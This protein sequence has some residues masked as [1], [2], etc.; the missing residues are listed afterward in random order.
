MQSL[1]TMASVLYL[2][3]LLPLI[4]INAQETC[5]SCR[6]SDANSGPFFSYSYCEDLDLCLE[7]V[8]NYINY[9]CETG[10]IKGAKMT[11]DDC[12]VT[13]KDD[14]PVFESSEVQ[15]GIFTNY[16]VSL[17]RGE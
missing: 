3:F 4:Q 1:K 17:I 9:K 12:G 15:Y 6:W 14:C 13:L 8:K 2:F 11:N 5:M 16:T 7:N 10:W